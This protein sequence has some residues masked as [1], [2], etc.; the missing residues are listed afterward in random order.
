MAKR[1][2]IR[3]TVRIGSMASAGLLAA[4]LTAAPAL[5]TPTDAADGRLV[6]TASGPVLGSVGAEVREFDGI[7]YAA[8]PVGPLRWTAPRPVTPW[9][10]PRNATKPGPVCAQLPY[11]KPVGSAVSEDCLTLNVTTPRGASAA[12]P[13]MV[14]LHGGDLTSGSGSQF[15]PRRMAAQGDVVVVT[16][17]YRLGIFGFFG[18]AGL[19]GSGTFGLQDQQAAL[20]WIRRNAAAFGGDARNVTLFGQSAGAI[21]TCGQLTSPAA[22]GLYD[23]VIIQSASCGSYTPT[24]MP[25]RQAPA[26]TATD[27]W[28]PLA[29]VD[30]QGGALARDLGCA[31]EATA[32]ACLR[33]LPTDR[34]LPHTEEFS[35]GAY[36]TPTL[37]VD[38]ETAIRT[39]RFAHVPT[40]IGHTRDE[41][42]MVTAALVNPAI[43]GA[44]M[45]EQRYVRLTD[46]AYGTRAAEVRRHYPPSA[47]AAAGEQWAPALAWAAIETDR[48]T[49]CPVLRDAD[50]LA[51]RTPVHAYEF[52]D[53]NAP[54]WTAFPEGF[55]AG[56]SHIS[57]LTYLFDVNRPDGTPVTLDS[58]QR[59]LAGTMIGYWTAFARAGAPAADGAPAW[60]AYAP[61][62]GPVQT[63]APA[64]I[65]TV[66][67]AT[68]HQCAFWKTAE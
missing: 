37:P 8:P 31:D 24:L 29:A 16:V 54:T 43:G 42:R 18:H 66:D 56:A 60:K 55:P 63:L 6:R 3:N 53:P 68:E 50:A 40:V 25:G 62:D 12:R 47:Y 52:A 44:P 51:R 49:V 34:L 27:K 17:N 5:A 30:A 2:I 58:A 26:T 39:G 7:P 10:Q 22:K 14:F 36:G 32:I 35:S 65:G 46:Q 9:S 59:G 41:G 48:T 64:R 1:E 45:T 13:V 38:P 4:G 15:E 11:N 20:R 28:R 21:S 23:K 19:P 57:D 33:G 61:G 67:D